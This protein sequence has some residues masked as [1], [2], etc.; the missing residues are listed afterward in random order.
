M[1]G[2]LA[3]TY[4]FLTK[5]L[6]ALRAQGVVPAVIAHTC[7]DRDDDAE[8]GRPRL[9]VAELACEGAAYFIKTQTKTRRQPRC[10]WRLWPT[11]QPGGTASR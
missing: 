9:A 10:P 6:A 8:S 4:G 11:N 2:V 7:Y 5:N 3:L 1:S